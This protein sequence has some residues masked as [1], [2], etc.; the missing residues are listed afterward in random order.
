MLDFSRIDAALV[1]T[2]DA[3]AQK[4]AISR[5]EQIL[6]QNGIKMLLE[7]H[8]AHDL[9]RD[10]GLSKDEI[11]ARTKLVVSLG[12]D[13]NYIGACRRFS[14]RGAYLF[15]VHTGSLGFLTDVLIDE[16]ADFLNE[17]KRGEFY[18]QKP[19]FLEAKL[20]RANASIS[21]LAFN[22]ITLMRE[23]INST[24]RIDAFLDAKYFN[25]YIGDGIIASSPMGS[26]AYNM[27]AGG[28]IMH[29]DCDIYSLTPICSHALTQRPLIL[30][31]SYE[32]ELRSNDDVIV[33]LDG[34]DYLRLKDYDSVKISVSKQS[35]NLIRRKER[36]YFEVLKQKLRWGHQ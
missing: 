18:V 14:T 19:R 26:T 29:P 31:S 33:L 2:R 13:G 20:V 30:P 15:G 11:F 3:S 12:G 4:L 17:L 21:K 28:A 24:T 35:I 10:D 16:C 25:S 8:S 23:K 5:L 32:I 22:D 9:R 6:K 7:A 36:D 1:T 34:Q 27:S